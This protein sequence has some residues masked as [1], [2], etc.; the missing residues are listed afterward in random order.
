MTVCS[1]PATILSLVSYFFLFDV[2]IIQKIRITSIGVE[3]V[4]LKSGDL[5]WCLDFRDMS[6]PAIVLL[7]D[8]YGRKGVDNGGFVLCPLYGRKSKAFQAA[9]GSSTNVIL[10]NMV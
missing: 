6:S 9:S 2:Y 1:L 8:T 5:R 10:S 3:L 4:D 7:A